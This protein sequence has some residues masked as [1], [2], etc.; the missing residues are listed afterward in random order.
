MILVST[1]SAHS[2]KSVIVDGKFFLVIR[3]APYD[4]HDRY[5]L[6]SL[7][8]LCSLKAASGL[9]REKEWFGSEGMEHAR[10]K[11]TPIQSIPTFAETVELLMKVR[12]SLI[13]GSFNLC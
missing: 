13:L 10:T 2:T 3:F 11:K 5:A 8:G 4:E 1:P 9:I 7:F 6:V 12:G